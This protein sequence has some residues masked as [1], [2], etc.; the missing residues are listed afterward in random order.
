MAVKPP[1]ACFIDFPIGSPIGKPHSP[2]LQRQV[3][4]EIFDEAGKF[5]PDWAMRELPFN[6]SEDGSRSWEDELKE[7]YRRGLHT[8]ENHVADHGQRGEVLLGREK[9][10]ALRCNC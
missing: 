1:R 3:L 9:N 5:A 8:V 4:K 10:F 2:E 7:L 6:W